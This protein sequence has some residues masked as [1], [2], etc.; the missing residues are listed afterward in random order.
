M[1]DLE[2]AVVDFEKVCGC[3]I[4]VHDLAGVF[5][6]R[7]RKPM[8]GE[9]RASHRQSYTECAAEERD[10][11]VKHCMFDF[12]RRVNESG[13]PCY[14]KRC[15]RR[16]LEVAIPLYRQQNQ[17]ATLFAGLWKHPSGAEAERIRRLCNVLP[18][19]G[20]GLLRRAEF[21]RRHPESGFRYRDEIAGFV[22]AHF[23]R[24]VSVADLARKLSLSVSR[25][26]HLTRTLFGKSFSALLVAERLEHARIYLA[27]SD[28]RV[29]EIG[30]LCGFGSAEHFCRMFTRHCKMPPGEYRKTHRP[31]I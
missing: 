7:D 28:Y 4:T 22:E 29:G 14:L 31:T 11:C 26:C 5:A 27:S 20:E 8:L 3:K 2:P 15:R 16:L 21:L 9:V 25:T 18:V 10:Y 19:F 17:V 12:N 1:Y 30:L 6:H 24:P 23:N 13:R